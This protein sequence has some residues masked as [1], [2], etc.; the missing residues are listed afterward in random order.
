M[1]LDEGLN[2]AARK[3][4]IEKV[5][6][7]LKEGVDPNV[8]DANGRTPLHHA[9]RG[10]YIDI[11]SFLLERKADPNIKD[12]SGRTPLHEAASGGH[13]DVI[14]LLLDM[15]MDLN[16]RDEDGETLLHCAAS[17]DIIEAFRPLGRTEEWPVINGKFNPA[18]LYIAASRKRVNTVIFLLEKGM[19]PNARAE[20]S[21]TPLHFAASARASR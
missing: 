3:G 1:G 19:D 18:P 2:E 6:K 21:Q 17:R 20:N 16:S 15:G 7:L 5:R 4:N 13:A 12:E 8:K 10:G 9:A 11:I 14:R